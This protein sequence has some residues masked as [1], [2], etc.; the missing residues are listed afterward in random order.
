MSEQPKLLLLGVINFAKQEWQELVSQ[1]GPADAIATPDREQLIKD[2]HGKYSKVEAIYV[3]HGAEASIKGVDAELVKELPASLKFVCNF[4]AGYDL[5]D[6][7]ALGARGIQ[8]SNTPNYVN[9]ATATTAIYLML[10]ALRNYYKM[11]VELRKGNW[12]GGVKEAHDPEGKVLGIL[13][14][15]G[16]GKAIRDKAAGFHF[17][18]IVY[19]NRKPLP[20]EEAGIAEYAS[21]EELLKIS[22]VISVSVP[23]NKNTRHL[24]NKD[25][26]AQCKDG[27][28]I[29]NTAR[30]PVIDEQALVDAL[31]SGKV[32]TVGLDV[33]EEEP[34]IHPK[35]LANENITLLP[36]AGTHTQETRKSMEEGVMKNIKAGLT[37]GKVVDLV[38]EQASLF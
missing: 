36:H 24:I 21:F 2:F 33:F 30:G 26:L 3:T 35:L 29:V 25:T 10:G 28:V 11:E 17:K 37:T 38:P 13:G 34:K 1:F 5:L 32:S 6:I 22:D 31:E 9:E 14:M 23:L 4:G 12:L 18:K 15:G 19:Y 7:H 27:V 8:V 20:A 16:I